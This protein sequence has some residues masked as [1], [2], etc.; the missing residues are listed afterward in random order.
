M[1]FLRI[2]PV[3]L[4]GVKYLMHHQ[5][6]VSESQILLKTAWMLRED[7][8]CFNLAKSRVDTAP[9]LSLVAS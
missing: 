3:T 6:V 9:G 7:S 5:V 2:P 4:S 1:T 8:G